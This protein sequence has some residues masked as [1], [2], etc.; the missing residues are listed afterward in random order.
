MEG[1]GFAF[2]SSEAH[3]GGRI[4]RKKIITKV[5]MIYSILQFSLCW[6]NKI[7]HDLLLGKYY[8][9]KVIDKFALSP[10]SMGYY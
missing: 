1:H 4:K 9:K 2:P 6:L 7:S 10:Y 8:P 3:W 5:E